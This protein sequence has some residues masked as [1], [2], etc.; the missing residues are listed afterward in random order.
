MVL[1]HVVLVGCVGKKAI[2]VI[3]AERATAYVVGVSSD[4]R[5]R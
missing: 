4:G 3:V 5:E 1:S 2:D